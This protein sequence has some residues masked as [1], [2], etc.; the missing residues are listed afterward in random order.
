MNTTNTNTENEENVKIDPFETFEPVEL[1]NLDNPRAS[2]DHFDREFI[3]EE[4][5]RMCQ[6]WFL[7]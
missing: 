5:K 7:S 4:Y 3:D 2:I 6:P 1:E